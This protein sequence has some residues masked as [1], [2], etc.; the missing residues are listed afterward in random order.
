MNA[1]LIENTAVEKVFEVTQEHMTVSDFKLFDISSLTFFGSGEFLSYNFVLEDTKQ[2]T[3]RQVLGSKEESTGLYSLVFKQSS[4]LT[5]TKIAIATFDNVLALLGGYF[6]IIFGLF[7][8]IVNVQKSYKIDQHLINLIYHRDSR[9]SAEVE[10][11]IFKSSK[12]L[13]SY[14][15]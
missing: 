7:S 4:K 3:Y 14:R 8:T 5:N 1:Q 10:E 12:N 15:F 6:A 2:K 11:P 9:D 13:I